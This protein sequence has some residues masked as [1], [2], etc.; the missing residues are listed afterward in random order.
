[1]PAANG[2]PRGGFTSVQI[3]TDPE[4]MNILH[5]AANEPSLVVDPTAPNRMAVGWRQFDDVSSNFRQAGY[6]YSRDGGRTWSMPGVIEPG[7]F[8]SDP[9]LRSD[10]HGKFFYNSYNAAPPTN[11]VQLFSSTDGGATWGNSVP[12]LGGDKVWITIDQTDGIGEGNIYQIWNS[13]LFNRSINRGASFQQP[14]SVPLS[15]IGTVAVGNAGEVYAVGVSLRVVKSLNAQDPMAVPVFTSV[16]VN[17]GGPVPGF[18]GPNPGGAL[19]QVWI[20]VD[21][22]DGP[23]RGWVYLVAI[24][25]PAGTDPADIVFSSSADGGQ[26]WTAPVRINNDPPGA[27][28]WQWFSTMAVAPN[29]RIDVVWNDTRESNQVNIS[30]TYY[31]SSIDGGQT[32]QGNIPLGPAWDSF[33]GWPNQNKI[34]D[35]Y[36]I[37]SDRVGADLVYATTYNGEQDVYYVRIGDHD[38]NGNGISDEQEILDNPS[39]D[40]A[41]VDGDG[42]VTSADFFLF[43]NLFLESS[44]DADFNRD[45]AINTQDYFDFLG[46]FFQGC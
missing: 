29:G 37:H 39:L 14:R 26:T 3:N 32:W 16:Q 2:F 10:R 42:T 34:G 11:A 5:D 24:I 46:A 17:L 44:P 21:R 30:R 6:S 33:V 36:D 38:C 45:G 9:V 12:T 8:R 1:V 22:S 43:V 13:D 31:A 25:D 19:G 28:H 27:N 23:R 18:V 15:W 20:D 40:A 41:D 4:G 35:Y 7:I